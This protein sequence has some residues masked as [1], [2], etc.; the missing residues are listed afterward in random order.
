M[1]GNVQ[2]APSDRIGAGTIF[3]A[4]FLNAA[5]H[6]IGAFIIVMFAA[7][8]WHY[9]AGWDWFNLAVLGLAAWIGISGLYR[10]LRRRIGKAGATIACL[11]AALIGWNLLDAMNWHF[12]P[13]VT[14]ARTV[15][16]YPMRPVHQLVAAAT[17][18]RI[19]IFARR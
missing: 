15:G 1:R 10:R 18:W 12:R 3:L 19:D 13:S 6:W 8:Y 2:V 17:G 14:I 4:L 16:V 5:R 11:V 9:G 7:A